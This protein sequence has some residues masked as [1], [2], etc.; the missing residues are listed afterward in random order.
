M[1]SSRSNSTL[2]TNH[3]RGWSVSGWGSFATGSSQQP[4]RPCPL[5]R[6]ELSCRD[7]TGTN[8]MTGTV[9][10]NRSSVAKPVSRPR[11]RKPA[12]VSA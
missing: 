10:N 3:M 2:A 5:C 8:T 6:C 12:T 11:S 9:A 1:S 4:A 7:A